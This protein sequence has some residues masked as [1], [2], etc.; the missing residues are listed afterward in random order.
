[1]NK[2]GA[3][4][5]VN[6]SSIRNVL[7]P[8]IAETR[9][10]GVQRTGRRRKASVRHG[11]ART[12]CA[13]WHGSQGGGQCG[14]G[15][16]VTASGLVEPWPWQWRRLR[17]TRPAESAWL[18]SLASE[19]SR[20]DIVLGLYSR[21]GTRWRRSRSRRRVYRLHG[22]QQPRRRWRRETTRPAA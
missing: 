4:S 16:A 12:S 15:T 17:R 7:Y 9:H 5:H 22:L 13:R 6:I 3:A 1:M 11:L 18:H 20:D 8:Q 14:D 21:A 10:D 19:T 2:K